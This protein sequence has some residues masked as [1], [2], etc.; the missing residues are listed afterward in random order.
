MG[1]I[2]TIID[3]HLADNDGDWDKYK[4]SLEPATEEEQYI[5]HC[6]DKADSDYD[7]RKLKEK[8]DE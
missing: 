1:S 5:E 4:E 2:C 3:D 8:E 6:F 7:E